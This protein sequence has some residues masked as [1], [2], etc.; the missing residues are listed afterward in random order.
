MAGN[1][2]RERRAEPQGGNGR[3][4]G[5]PQGDRPDPAKQPSAMRGGSQLPGLVLL[6]PSWRRLVTYGPAA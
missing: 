2:V 4:A 3:A 1:G 6:G 5:D